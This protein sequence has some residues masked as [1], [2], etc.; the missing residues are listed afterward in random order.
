[1]IPLVLR[2]DLDAMPLAIL[3]IMRR[4]ITDA[5]LIPQLRSDLI[6]RVLDFTS[7]IICP[8]PG[9]KPCFTAARVGKRVEN[10]H[11]YRVLADLHSRSAI[12]GLWGER[13]PA[14]RSAA[15]GNAG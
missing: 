6:Q 9:K 1:M 3:Q 13:K 10:S 15:A 5:V 4:V 7:A 11:I 2:S 8:V 14:R 12:L